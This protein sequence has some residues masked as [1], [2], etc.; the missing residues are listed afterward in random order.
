MY[1]FTQK[2]LLEGLQQKLEGLE[3]LS[4]IAGAVTANTALST[5]LLS[6]LRCSRPRR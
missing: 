1:C 2:F 6:S 4:P 5:D 3:P